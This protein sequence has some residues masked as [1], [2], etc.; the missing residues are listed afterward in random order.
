MGADF[1]VVSSR[2]EVELLEILRA[3]AANAEIVNSPNVVTR[4]SGY[5]AERLAPQPE[6]IALQRVEPDWSFYGRE[7][8]E[9][10]FIQ[11]AKSCVFRCAFCEFVVRGGR[12]EHLDLSTI[13]RQLDRIADLGTVKSIVFIDDTFNVPAPRF[14]AILRMMAEKRY[15]FKWSSFF[16]CDFADEEALDLLVAT[17]C[18]FLKLGLES[19]SQ[20]I[21]DTMI[22]GA[23]VSAYE[24]GIKGLNDR[25]IPFWASFIIG[26][27]GETEKTVE[28]TIAFI[29]RTQPYF[30]RMSPWYA[31]RM[32]SVMKLADKFGIVGD[33][34]NWRHK[35]MSIE[36]AIE[37]ADR[38]VLS[39]QN[40]VH[41]PFLVVEDII[42]LSH[43]GIR[44][45]DVKRYCALF[46]EGVK[47]RLRNRSDREIPDALWGDLLTILSRWDEIGPANRAYVG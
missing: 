10:A 40:S 19:G 28:E 16:R 4:S 30:Y 39:I 7:L 15:P 12:Y 8:K 42:S 23:T 41:L 35:T 43:L 46:N 20:Q 14:K 44:I 6:A 36:K 24:R 22:K 1:F 31:S 9:F 17:R 34:Y 21:L 3:L 11:T 37:E 2:G 27:P 18:E 5:S 26:F 33:G 25:G 13:E 47:R 29:E 32:T 45:D 38:A